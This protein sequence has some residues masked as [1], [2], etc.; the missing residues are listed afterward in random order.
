MYKNRY[1]YIGA[2]FM[3][4]Y[5][6]TSQYLDESKQEYLFDDTIRINIDINLPRSIFSSIQDVVVRFPGVEQF[7]VDVLDILENKYKFEV[8]EEMHDNKMQ[9]GYIS[10][11]ED[12]I[13][14]Y[15]NT[16]FDLTNAGDAFKRLGITNFSVPESGKVFCFV[17]LRFSDHILN[18]EGD[19]AHRKFVADNIEK[20]TANRPDV[21]H[22]VPDQQ[23]IEVPENLVYRYYDQALQSLEDDLD[24]HIIKWV[25]Q[26]DRYKR[27]GIE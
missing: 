23:D 11:R 24:L 13:S 5:I 17:Q 1:D 3:K 22:I 20:Y 14:L 7:R 18:D 4:R 8:I 16:Y 15:F 2:K 27:N 19:R 25:K 9:K 10:N 26:A 21:T 12:S 6:R